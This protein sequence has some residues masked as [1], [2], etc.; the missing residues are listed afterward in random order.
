MER[1]QITLNSLSIPELAAG[2]GVQGRVIDFIEQVKPLF[3]MLF[4]CQAPVVLIWLKIIPFEYRFHALFI[5]LAGLVYFCFSRRYRLAELGV[6]TD[7]LKN[8]LELNLWFCAIGGMI[9]Y[10]SLK[11]GVLIP[12]DHN[13]SVPHTYVT[14]IF[15]LGPVQELFFRSILYAEMQRG[16]FYSNRLFL[17]ISTLSFAFLHVIYGHPQ[18]LVIAL[19]SGLVWGILY[20]KQ[21]NISGVAL[22]HS[23]LGALSMIFEI[24]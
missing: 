6:R 16:Q 11:A 12:R 15:F 9:L 17:C 3:F 23:F 18:M 14:Y 21:P 8:A 10:L 19:V 13:A 7:T 4:M 1:K 22:S 5:A 20:I 24:I 2:F